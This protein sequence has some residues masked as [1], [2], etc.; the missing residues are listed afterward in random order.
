MGNINRE[1]TFVFSCLSRYYSFLSITKRDNEAIIHRLAI[2]GNSSN[3]DSVDINNAIREYRKSVDKKL[4]F[5]LIDKNELIQDFIVLNG[6][7]DE[8]APYMYK[9]N[10]YKK[11][12]ENLKK[13]YQRYVDLIAV[14]KELAER[15][16]NLVLELA[17][18][19]ALVP[20]NE[21]YELISS[22]E[23]RINML[24]PNV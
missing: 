22:I 19:R 10:I 13:N 11:Q 18:K 5:V 7:K 8:L 4:K 24:L 16:N 9:F 12:F 17:Y 2:Y 15:K 1:V 21:E 23:S 20:I 3:I 6:H 14:K